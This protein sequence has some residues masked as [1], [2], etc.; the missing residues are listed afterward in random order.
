ME[1][2]YLMTEEKKEL[3]MDE[4]KQN[5]L[6]KLMEKIAVL[7]KKNKELEAY[8]YNLDLAQSQDAV[9]EDMTFTMNWTKKEWDVVA[10]QMHD[11]QV[12]FEASWDQHQKELYQKLQDF[13]MLAQLSQANAK[14]S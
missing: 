3:T 13:Q 14:K 8:V 4:A 11:T 10:E 2:Y 1:V 12:A 9:K 7:N 5:Q 6:N